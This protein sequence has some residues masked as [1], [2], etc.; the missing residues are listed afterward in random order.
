MGGKVIRFSSNGGLMSE[1]VRRRCAEA[2]AQVVFE[3]DASPECR[4]P[5]GRIDTVVYELSARDDLCAGLEQAIA[6]GR[7]AAREMARRGGGHVLY[8]A[9]VPVEAA[10]GAELEAA[11]AALRSICSE[12]EEEWGSRGVRANAVAFADGVDPAPTAVFLISDEAASLTGEAV[13]LRGTGG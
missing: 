3:G 2:G 12:L 11:R 8:T 1:K 6:R 4:G 13:V 10:V 9:F 7:D 5:A